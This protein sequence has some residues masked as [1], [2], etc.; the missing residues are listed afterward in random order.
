MLSM[1]TDSE[2]ADSTIIRTGSDGRLRYSP[3]QLQTL[4]AD[5]KPIAA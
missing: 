5:M 2:P 3:D 4:L 1:P